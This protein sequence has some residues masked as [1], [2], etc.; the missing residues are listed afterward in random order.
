[1]IYTVI[2]DTLSGYETFYEGNDFIE[3]MRIFY[4]QEEKQ[5][6]IVTLYKGDYIIMES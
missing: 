6:G 5:S 1:M 2:H 3:A 4:E